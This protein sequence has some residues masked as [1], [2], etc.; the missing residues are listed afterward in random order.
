M[1]AL[2]PG[3]LETGM[4]TGDV[5]DAKEAAQRRIYLACAPA[6]VHQAG[7]TDEFFSGRG[8]NR[9]GAECYAARGARD[10]NNT[11]AKQHAKCTFERRHRHS[12]RPVRRGTTGHSGSWRVQRP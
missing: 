10:T 8:L 2:N 6:E 3:D 7:A 11:G 9:Y 4:R 1:P 12:L 5:P